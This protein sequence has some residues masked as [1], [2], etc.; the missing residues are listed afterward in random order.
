MRDRDIKFL[1]GRSGNR[2]AI[3]KLELTTDGSSET[4]GEMAHIVGQS[5]NGPR[6]NHDLTDRDTYDNLILLCPTHHVEIDKNHAAWP[7]ER[8]RAIKADHEA[9][10]SEQLGT[11][12]F[13]VSPI[14]NTS[15]LAERKASWI[16]ACRGEVGMVLCLTPLRVSS[17]TLNPLD[18]SVTDILEQAR[19]PN[20]NQ[21]GEQV[22]RYR[23]RPT[24]FGIANQDLPAP[25]NTCGHSIQIFSAGH[26]EYFCELGE[27][28]NQVTVVSK[29]RGVDLKG[30]SRVLRYTDL[31]EIAHFGLDWLAHAWRTILP[32][33]YMT[34]CGAIVNTTSTTLYSREDHRKQG[35]HGFTVSSPILKYTEV[36]SKSFEKDT[37][38]LEFLRRI[39]NSYG[40][41]LHRVF[42]DKGEYVRPEKM[43]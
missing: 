11:G 24:E 30:A 13:K 32:F 34:F 29:E 20:G 10:V 16:E 18:K 38:L 27:S 19:V 14:D 15:F 5:R 17:D 41:M 6:G 9:W 42:D 4:L 33:N 22:N 12:V 7:I 43:R 2:C 28:V 39:S 3:C 26:C 1:W 40:L 37:L 8:L 36:L 21:S 23:T 31:A 35:L 25:H